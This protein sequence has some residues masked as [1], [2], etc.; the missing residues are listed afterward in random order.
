MF[1]TLSSLSCWIYCYMRTSSCWPLK[2]CLLI[3]LQH[4]TVIIVI[5]KIWRR[6]YLPLPLVLV[7]PQLGH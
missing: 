6:I 1:L 5:N 2:Q 4:V 3:L 7:D